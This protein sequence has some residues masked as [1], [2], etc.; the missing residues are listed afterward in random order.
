[1]WIDGPLD[2]GSGNDGKLKLQFFEPAKFWTDAFPVGNG[3]LGA[4]VFGGVRTELVQL[5]GRIL[6]G[7]KLSI[8]VK[9]TRHMI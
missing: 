5:N 8:L 6:E 9:I 7:R 4:M 1:M 2:T 3:R